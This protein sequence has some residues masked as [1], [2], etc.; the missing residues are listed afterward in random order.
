MKKRNLNLEKKTLSF[1]KQVIVLLNTEQQY[2]ALGGGTFQDTNCQQCVFS[3][4]LS[5]CPPCQGSNPR[6]SHCP[7]SVDPC[8]ICL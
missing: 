5:N 8:G 4:Q 1:D 7:I 2:Q 3:I 6:Q